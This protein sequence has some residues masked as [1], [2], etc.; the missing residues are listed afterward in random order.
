MIAVALLLLMIISFIG[1]VCFIV[2]SVFNFIDLKIG[3]GFIF[4]VMF[5]IC[6]VSFIKSGVEFN[7][8]NEQETQ[9]TQKI[10]QEEYILTD[11][12]G[13]KFDVIIKER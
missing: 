5:I 8:L 2:F 1:M 7:K 12:D 10:Q 9:E 11:K 3:L 4:G 6:F 13:N